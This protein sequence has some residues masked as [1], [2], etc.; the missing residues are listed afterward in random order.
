MNHQ[1]FQDHLSDYI[2]GDLSDETR[3]ALDN[4]MKGCE[5]C[6]VLWVTTNK[7]IELSREQNRPKLSKTFQTQLTH[8]VQRAFR[9]GKRCEG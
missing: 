5:N 8:K 1:Q 7:A 9:L 3:S 2:D 4:H 6:R